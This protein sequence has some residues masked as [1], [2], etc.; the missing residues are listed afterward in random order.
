MLR[1]A[2]PKRY[3]PRGTGGKALRSNQASGPGWGSWPEAMRSGRLASHDILRECGRLP[4]AL[5]TVGALLRGAT[6]A[7]W[8]DTAELLHNADLAA[9]EEQLPPG[10][11]SFFRAIDLS[12][13]ALEPKIEQQYGRLAVLLEDMAAS[14]PVLETLWNVDDAEARRIARRLADRSLAQRDDEGGM[15]LHDLQLDYIRAKVPD[16]KALDLIHG[17]VRLSAHVIEKDPRQFA[18]QVLGRLLPHRNAPAIQQFIEE[19]AAGAPTP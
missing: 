1:P 19:I 9:I 3:E 14:L 11:Q 5:S 4:L 18:S 7:E 10:Q 8:A 13:K 16:R 17:A 12:V 6:P 15:R 2:L